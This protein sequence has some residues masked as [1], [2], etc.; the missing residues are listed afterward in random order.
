VIGQV[1]LGYLRE[2][3]SSGASPLALT[4]QA[5]RSMANG[6][7]VR[8]DLNVLGRLSDGRDVEA[9]F[10]DGFEP[11]LDGAVRWA[12]GALG[13]AERRLNAF[14]RAGDAERADA[15]APAVRPILDQLERRLEKVF[16][17]RVRRTAH[18]RER[19]EEGGRPT[20]NAVE[21]ARRAGDHDVLFDASEETIVVVGAKGRVHVFSPGGRLVTSIVLSRNEV[22]RRLFRKR[23]RPATRD[24]I[25]AF[26]RALDPRP[27][28]GRR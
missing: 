13:E 16:R 11:D 18:A 27:E 26:R 15:V 6:G 8:L 14:R 21:D 7:D 2:P 23:W 1:A 5:V 24:E 12:R 3:E 22:D 25:E 4:L 19:A 9:I 17:Q 20:R 10:S 28:T